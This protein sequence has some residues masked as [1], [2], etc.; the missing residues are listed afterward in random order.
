M[1]KRR[2]D[3]AQTIVSA[4]ERVFQPSPSRVRRGFSDVGKADWL[5]YGGLALVAFAVFFYGIGDYGIINGNESLYVESARE[6]ALTGQWAVPSLNG[7][8]YLENRCCSSGCSRC[9]A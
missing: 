1:T 5:A 8:P 7:L 9:S 4:G 6:M 3:A 2:T